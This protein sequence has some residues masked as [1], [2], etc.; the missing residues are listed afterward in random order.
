MTLGQEARVK[1]INQRCGSFCGILTPTRAMFGAVRKFS[2]HIIPLASSIRPLQLRGYCASAHAIQKAIEFSNQAMIRGC[3]AE[4]TVQ[5]A[6][7]HAT[8]TPLVSN[9]NTSLRDRLLVSRAYFLGALPE[10][11][12]SLPFTFTLQAI[13]ANEPGAE[14]VMGMLYLGGGRKSGVNEIEDD[15]DAEFVAVQDSNGGVR[16]VEK[17]VDPT[18]L[19]I[20]QNPREIVKQIVNDEKQKR[21]A[22]AQGTDLAPQRS[23]DLGCAEVEVCSHRQIH[24]HRFFPLSIQ[25][26]FGFFSLV[27]FGLVWFHL[28][29]F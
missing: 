17:G 5:L 13:K 9:T 21:L 24:K 11:P 26:T 12:A 28:F 19:N 20:P 27:W 7:L 10:L 15:E 6:H 1:K 23:I 18:T 22:K 8:I 25:N 4:D 3:F 14:F 29:Y 2:S 16:L